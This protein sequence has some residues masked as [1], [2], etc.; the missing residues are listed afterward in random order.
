M[1]ARLNPSLPPHFWELDPIKNFQPLCVDILAQEPGIATAD[2]YG[3]SGQGDRGVDVLGRDGNGQVIVVGQCKRRENCT[4]ADVIK[5]GDDFYKHYQHWKDKGVTKFILFVACDLTDKK[6]Q[7]EIQNQHK[8]F[9]N[10]GIHFEAWSGSILRNKLT[11]YPQI[12]QRHI[13]SQEVLRNICGPNIQGLVFTPNASIETTLQ[14]LREATREPDRYYGDIEDLFD[15]ETRKI[16]STVQN[17]PVSFA[18]SSFELQDV[19]QKYLQPMINVSERLVKMS[20]T[21]I[22]FDRK[23]EFT[24]VLI[25]VFKLLAQDPLKFENGNSISFIPGVPEIGLYPLALMIYSVYIVGIEYKATQLLSSINKIPF[26]SRR[27]EFKD[28]NL[29]GVLW[30]MYYE[31][32]TSQFFKA[33]SPNTTYPI[34]ESIKNILQDWL[35]EYLDFPQDAYYHGEFILS[36]NM[37]DSNSS[38]SE[39]LFPSRYLYMPEAKDILKNFITDEKKSLQELCPD[40]GYRLQIFDTLSSDAARKFP[41]QRAYG[42]Y[43]NAFTLYNNS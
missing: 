7:D 8:R 29:L 38:Y 27:D 28:Q 13:H 30:H 18:R 22:K 14:Q 9:S 26:R 39:C 37:L 40:I 5:A 42:F 6:V 41:F 2:E 34:P 43:G 24:D 20:A 16:I 1:E 17:P 10:I 32:I 19:A 36:L 3:T 11:P 31:N 25:K 35:Q 4:A 23:R 33:I 12:A 21:L 15:A